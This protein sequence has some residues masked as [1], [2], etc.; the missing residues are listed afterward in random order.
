MVY[1]VDVSHVSQFLRGV[2]ISQGLSERHLD[3]RSSL[4]E[5]RSFEPGDCLYVV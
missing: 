5:E 2:D 4:C 1:R 3:R